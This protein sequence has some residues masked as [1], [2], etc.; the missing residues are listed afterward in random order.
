MTNELIDNKLM[1]RL[2]DVDINRYLLNFYVY[3]TLLVMPPPAA[4]RVYLD[5][6]INGPNTNKTVR[7]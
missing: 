2:I 7:L 3:E 6:V 1:D 4:D 5:M